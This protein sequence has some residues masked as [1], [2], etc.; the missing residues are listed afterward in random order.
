[1]VR[2]YNPWPSCYTWYQ[3]KRLKIHRAIP[4]GDAENGEIGKVIAVAEQPGVAV[5]TGQG[6]LGLCEVQLEGKRAM[7]V[8][9][10]VRGQRD[11]IGSVVGRK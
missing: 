7:P 8:S 3:G 10:F 9:D 5:V 4:L 2:A 1:M 11:F 6:A